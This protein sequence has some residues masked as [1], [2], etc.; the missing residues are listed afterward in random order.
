MKQQTADI[1]RFLHRGGEWSYFWT[2]PD[3]KTTWYKT[4]SRIPEPPKA[5]GVYFGVHPTDQNKANGRGSLDIISA[6]NCLFSEFDEKDFDNQQTLNNHLTKLELSPSIRIKSGGGVHCYWLLDQPYKLHDQDARDHARRLQARW[7]QFTGGDQGSKDLARVLRMPGTLNK[8]YDPPRPVEIEYCDL[9]R[10]FSLAEL[11]AELP[12]EAPQIEYSSVARVQQMPSDQAGDYW[13]QRATQR[14]QVGNRNYTGLWLALQLRDAGLSQPEV[15]NLLL[16][17]Q[18]RVT[19]GGNPYTEE[20]AIATAESAFSRPP[21]RAAGV[22]DQYMRETSVIETA[23]ELG[24]TISRTPAHT[25]GT[26][27]IEALDIHQP[28]PETIEYTSGHSLDDLGNGERLVDLYGHKIHWIE[29]AGKWFIYDGT[30]WAADHCGEI[31]RLA[32]ETAKSIFIEANRADEEQSKEIGKWAAKSQSRLRRISMIE[33]AKSEPNITINITEFDQNPWL[34]NFKNG[35]LNLQTGQLQPHKPADLISKLINLD[36]S[37]DAECPRWLKFLDEIMNGNKELIQFL[38]RAAGY[39][40]T[41]VDYEQMFLLCYGRG[42]NG[43]SVF[44]ETLLNALGADYAKNT[45]PQTIL[46]KDRL[47]TTSQEIAVLRGMRLVTVNEI[48]GRRKLDTARIKELTGSDTITA[49]F[50]FHEDFNFRPEFKLWMRTNHKPIITDVDPGI[51]RR[52]RLIPFTVTIPKEKQDPKLQEKLTKEWPGIIAWGVRGCLDWQTHGLG[53][54]EEVKAATDEYK[55]EQD[56]FQ[57]FIDEK[58]SLDPDAFIMAKDL[59]LAYKE[60]CE[61]NGEKMMTNT[62]F[63]RE[64]GERGFE[65]KRASGGRGN[66]YIGIRLK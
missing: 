15:K 17:Y 27:T 44:L 38:Q 66:E 47:T 65:K 51:W 21:R 8:K 10:V 58:C 6:I 7:V 1:L 39:S 18:G 14:A 55:S 20:E 4:G 12:P 24:A 40:L 48:P 60:W 63:G 31:E 32:K 34:L 2:M 33:D 19:N 46:A 5:D 54:P 50:L 52:V 13:L 41:G 61:I 28:P 56:T 26:I 16:D 25:G 9:Q 23:V 57:P 53:M 62:A 49:R 59:Y 3:K 43:K 36:Y 64:L 30:R 45:Q 11:A 37:A 29:A 35:T 22:K 42:A